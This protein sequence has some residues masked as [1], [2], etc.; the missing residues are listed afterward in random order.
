MLREQIVALVRLHG[1]P[2]W[3]LERPEPERLLLTAAMRIDTRL[4]ALLARADLLGRQSPISNQ[5]WNASICSSC[6]A[7]SNNAGEKCARS[8]LIPHAGTT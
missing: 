6:F 2:L 3:L 5:C 4:L 8:F 1:L 7:M